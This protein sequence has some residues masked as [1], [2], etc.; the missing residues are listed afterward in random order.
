MPMEMPTEVTQTLIQNRDNIWAVV[1]TGIFSFGGAYAVVLTSAADG[2][3][4]T[5]DEKKAT[6]FIGTLV[7]LAFAS[8]VG[9]F[10]GVPFT[11]T[12]PVVGSALITGS[13]GRPIMKLIMNI[14]VSLP[15]TKKDVQKD[16]GQ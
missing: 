15:W 4:M 14:P 10:L 3:P 2:K 9:S 12:I 6:L 8:T 13:L 16:S 5:P 7:G 1:L 11:K